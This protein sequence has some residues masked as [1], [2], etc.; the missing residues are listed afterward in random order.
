MSAFGGEKWSFDFAPESSAFGRHSYLSFTIV[1][2]RAEQREPK[3]WQ[4]HGDH[5]RE[6]TYARSENETSKTSTNE[7]TKFRLRSEVAS[8]STFKPSR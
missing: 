6:A 7:L 8:Q 3:H 2:C 4:H 1:A 5:N